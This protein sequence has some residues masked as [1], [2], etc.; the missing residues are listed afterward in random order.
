MRLPSALGAVLIA[1]S[2][3][4]LRLRNRRQLLVVLDHDS[5]G[6]DSVRVSHLR[7]LGARLLGALTPVL[8]VS[9]RHGSPFVVPSGLIW[10][11]IRAEVKPQF[12][13]GPYKRRGRYADGMR[14]SDDHSPLW[15]G[16]Q[17]AGCFRL[18]EQA[19][20]DKTHDALTEYGQELLH[21]AERMERVSR[22]AERPVASGGGPAGG[23][24]GEI[25]RW[26][27]KAEEARAMAENLANA[28]ARESLIELAE[29]YDRL[30][31]QMEQR[32]ARRTETLQ[33]KGGGA[34]RAGA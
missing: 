29:H 27:S 11:R 28:I 1:I 5:H 24:L 26:R 33:P 25:Q 10:G 17:A 6:F 2:A 13:N 19:W 31:E 23:L 12:G 16:E 32:A 9:Q 8:R 21:R 7:Q 3:S 20:D 15:L 4:H 14:S 34:R 18:A 22:L 30:A